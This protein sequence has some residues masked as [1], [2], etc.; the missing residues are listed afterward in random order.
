LW[1][2]GVSLLAVLVMYLTWVQV[3]DTLEQFA[4][5]HSLHLRL[6]PPQRAA[7]LL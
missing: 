2:S 4:L 7:R 3:L 1:L 6:L 5:H